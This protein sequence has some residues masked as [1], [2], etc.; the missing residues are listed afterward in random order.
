MSDYPGEFEQLVL[1]ALIRLGKDAYG[2]TIRQEVESRT[3]RNVSAGAVYTAL[4][5]MEEKGFVTSRFGEPTRMRG[6][7]RKKFYKLEPRGAKALS[8]AYAAVQA[9]A[10]GIRSFNRQK[11]ES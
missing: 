1:F 7:K 8:R 9:M 5:R 4:E 6:G 10:G 3:K 11:F 2:V